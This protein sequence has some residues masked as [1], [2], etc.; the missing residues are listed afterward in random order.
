VQAVADVQETPESRLPVAPP[1]LGVAWITQS[2]PF[3]R[4]TS[5]S[6]TPELS[7]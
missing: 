7:T 5:V 6:S 1:G 2:L 4:S 3:H